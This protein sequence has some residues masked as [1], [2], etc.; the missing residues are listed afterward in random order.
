MSA[1]IKT[2]TPFTNQELLLEALDELGVGC[3]VEGRKIITD[4]QDYYGHQI[5]E[6]SNNG[7]FH[8]Q[9]DSSAERT[10]YQ[11]RAI[12]FREWKTV[13]SFLE[14][15]DQAYKTAYGRMLDHLAE[16]ERQREEERKRK[17]VEDVRQETI[18][19]ARA[20]GYAIKESKQSGKIQLVLTRTIY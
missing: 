6:L 13:T 16:E 19:R 7:A 15:V 2:V 3:H 8:F 1:V 12:N 14:A 18:A 10:N 9:H 17:Y 5:F 4:R 20:Q 11:W